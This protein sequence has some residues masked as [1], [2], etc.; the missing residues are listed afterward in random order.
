MISGYLLALAQLDDPKMRG[1][2]WMSL[3]LSVVV[4]ALV[5]FVA[6]WSLTEVPWAD[7]PVIGWVVGW[8]GDWFGWIAAFALGGTML[9]ATFVLFPAVMTGIAGIF[10]DRVVEV[11]EAR[12]Y[13]GNVATRRI[14]LG[15]AL[16][17]SVKFIAVM[18]IVNIIAL[19]VYG[20]LLFTAIG[21][22]ILYY[23]INGYLVGREFYEVVAFRRLPPD[24]AR[25][26]RKAHRGR[27][28]LFGALTAFL[29]T[30]PLVNLI[31]P[32]LATAA[33]THLFE[34]LPRRRE[35]EALST[36]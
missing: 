9:L 26:L 12:H 22:L 17:N 24:I 34:R 19:P 25:Q 36:G 13:P 7:V 5:W 2:V 15:E 16:A 32:V 21:P 6:G 18:I 23:L 27:V 28:W 20:I 11:V 1:V 29:L 30:V 14:G 31:T 10:L 35:Y 8:T 3:G 4:F 33:M